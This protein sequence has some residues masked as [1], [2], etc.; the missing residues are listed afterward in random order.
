VAIIATFLGGL[1]SGSENLIGNCNK[2]ATFLKLVKLFSNIINNHNVQF[3]NIYHDIT[4]MFRYWLYKHNITRVLFYYF[5]YLLIILF[6][7]VLKIVG[8]IWPKKGFSNFP[9]FIT[10]NI[11]FFPVCQRSCKVS[12]RCR[13]TATATAVQIQ[14]LLLFSVLSHFALCLSCLSLLLCSGAKLQKVFY[15]QI[16]SEIQILGAGTDIPHG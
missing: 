4:Y 7:Y 13:W 11:V 3:S 2:L 1:K 14:L 8:E 6:R 9:D 5:F 16:F 10:W 12:Q 15:M